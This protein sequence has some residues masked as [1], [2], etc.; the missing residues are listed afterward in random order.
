MEHVRI[1]QVPHL[2][3]SAHGQRP[4]EAPLENVD[5]TE[6][7]LEV[8]QDLSNRRSH[9]RIVGLKKQHF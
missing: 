1:F 2:K 8:S 5:L 7:F 4:P 3:V 9:L 6:G